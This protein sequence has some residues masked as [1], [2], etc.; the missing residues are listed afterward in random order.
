MR[1]TFDINKVD[2]VNLNGVDMREVYPVEN[3]G[4]SVEKIV[5]NMVWENAP[6][7]DMENIGRKIHGGEPVEL[8]AMEHELFIGLINSLS[9]VFLR[10]R[11]LAQV[12]EIT[13]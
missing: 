12:K 5:G 2:L 7:I 6:N 4:F 9:A 3:K 11:I 13:Q 8:S 10:K 1:Y